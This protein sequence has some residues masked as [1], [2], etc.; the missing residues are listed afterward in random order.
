MTEYDIHAAVVEYVQAKYKDVL[1]Y[2]DLNGVKLTI[3]QATK[4]KRLQMPDTKWLDLFFPEPRGAY[5]GLF[6]E[7]KRSRS[8]YRRKDGGIR[9]SEHIQAQLATMKA[10]RERGYYAEFA[11]YEKALYL[12]DWYFGGL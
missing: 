5:S 4:I 7:L 10:L 1:W 2:S 9:E 11:D 8:E 6:I 12:I 3:G